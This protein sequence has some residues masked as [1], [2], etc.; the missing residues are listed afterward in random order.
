MPELVDTHCHLQ[1]DQYG[2]GAEDTISRAV[3]DGVTR[4]IMVGT[5]GLDSQKAIDFAT[6]HD[7]V[8]ASVGLHPHYAN[9]LEKDKPMLQ[10]LASHPKVVAIGECGLDY[11]HNHSSK[12]NQAK[13]LRFQIEL[14][15]ERNLPI[16]FHIRDAYDDFWPIIDNYKGIKAVAHCF[17]TSQHELDEILKRG[18][19]VGLNGIVT[20]SKNANQITA[21][22]NVPLDK[23]LIETDAPYLTPAPLRG[24]INEPKNVVVIAEFLSNL[25]GESFD[26]LATASTANAHQLF[27]I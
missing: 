3:K 10:D 26:E 19:Y 5:N 11:Y 6:R 22:K 12:E 16:I 8:W 15:L 20:F 7:C 24:K 14:A 23:L 9:N 13:A 27:G 2:S 21:F 17:A 1:F 4:M 18:W 25:R